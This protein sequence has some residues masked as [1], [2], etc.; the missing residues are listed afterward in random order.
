MIKFFK[1]FFEGINLNPKATSGST[2]KGDLEVLSGDGRL[3]YNDGTTNDKVVSETS[4]DTLENKSIDADDNII[5]N[6]RD[7]EIAADAQIARTKLAD[8]TAY[9]VQVN[10]STGVQTDV[11]LTA[12]RALAS[13]ANGVPVAS[14][15]TATE[16]SYLDNVT[17]NIQ[18]QI[19][20]KVAKAGDT[21]TGNLDMG[22]NFIT[23]T[24]TPSGATELVNKSYVDSLIEGLD[25]KSAARVAT[26]GPGTLATSFENGDTI[27]GVV[28]ATNDRILIKNQVDQEENGIYIVQATGA[29]VRSS[30]ANTW[31][32]LISAQ[33]F[34]QSGTVNN[35]TGW[36][37]TILA[38]GTLGVDPV[39]FVQQSGVGVIT[40]DGQGIEISG[41]QLSLELDGTSLSK[42]SSGLKVNTDLTLANS[43]VGTVSNTDL[44]LNPNGTGRV[45][46]N[47]THLFNA[48][49]L[50]VQADD[51]TLYVPSDSVSTPVT[52]IKRLT[53][54]DASNEVGGI[55]APATN[56][57]FFVLV[58][59]NGTTL[60]IKDESSS[61]STAANRIV[62]GT[63]ADIR[64]ADEAAL[65]LYYDTAQ[66]RW[67]IIGGSGGGGGVTVTGTFTSPIEISASGITA[68]Q[69]VS[70]D[71]YV[72]T[73]S[74]EVNVTANPQISAGTVDGQT[75]R[76]TGT[77]NDN[78]ILLEDGNGLSI[79][80]SWSSYLNN[81][82]SLRWDS[83]QSVWTEVTRSQ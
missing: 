82:L 80:G 77:S 7:A 23:S 51:A 56:S 34:V 43:T 38:G 59:K 42:S 53:N 79:Q 67:R 15:V 27:D 30:D 3:Y 2:K 71:I 9:A 33:I 44:T 73:A 41:N 58:N 35:N 50:G 66:L 32:E 74:G 76:I 11:V 18:D 69:G 75:L 6:L 22:S 16:L 61:V 39:T 54:I 48:A 46:S 83:T 19:N 40:T 62:T 5:T 45:V 57:L 78:Y 12:S 17:S 60:T 37:C 64:F 31:D 25:P 63:G 4:T 13:D 68:I 36:F 8:G 28:L 20:A 21:M 81:V 24:A 52:F 47:K 1:K 29:P 70:E 65:Y 26:T 72:D 55:V 10:N 14:D 49:L